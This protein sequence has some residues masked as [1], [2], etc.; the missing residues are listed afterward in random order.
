MNQHDV[1]EEQGSADVGAQRVARVY[2]EALLTAA[3]QAG[4]ADALEQEYASLLRDAF[5]A[6]Y[7]ETILC[8]GA[9]GRKHKAELIAKVFQGRASATFFNY[10]QVLNEHERLDLLRPIFAAFRQLREQRARRMRV[11]VRSAV[12][13]PADQRDRLVSELRQTFQVEPILQEQVDPDLLG[14]MVVR[15][16]DWVYDASIRRELETIRSELIARSSHEI[17]SRR[18][19]FCTQ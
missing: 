17:Q 2:A 4:Q 6:E 3:D 16:G 9:I 18:D 10:L 15:V 7:L 8:S 11:Q 12:A 5:Q 14:G 19:Q 13:L 1:L